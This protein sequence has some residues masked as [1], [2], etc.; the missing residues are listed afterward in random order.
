MEDS[1]ND[2]GAFRD[3]RLFDED[4]DQEDD[5]WVGVTNL[6]LDVPEEENEGAGQL[7]TEVQELKELTRLMKKT[8]VQAALLAAGMTSS[9]IQE[10][11]K[12]AA[13]GTLFAGCTSGEKVLQRVLERYP[14]L[15]AASG[16]L[17]TLKKYV[18]AGKK[19]R[20]K[21]RVIPQ[22]EMPPNRKY[23]T[24]AE[25]VR[26]PVRLTEEE[27]AAYGE[28]EV[29]DEDSRSNLDSDSLTCARELPEPKMRQYCSHNALTN[30]SAVDR[31]LK[32]KNM[33]H[34]MAHAE[35]SFATE[36]YTECAEACYNA[37]REKPSEAIRAR[38][39]MYL[40]TEAVGPTEPSG[41]A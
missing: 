24:R 25:K 5:E 38:C 22:E 13:E 30:L 18:E 39:H 35:R 20:S 40:A 23:E 16:V 2:F 29:L 1:V 15:R 36:R 7:A 19:L 26:A 11:A 34:L 4:L 12:F 27:M 6:S 32:Q 28:Q 17:E 14:A 9:Q 8:A 3:A 31:S 33:V 37:L 10:F 41:R 21:N